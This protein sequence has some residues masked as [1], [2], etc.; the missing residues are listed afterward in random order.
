MEYKYNKKLDM[1]SWECFLFSQQEKQLYWEEGVKNEKLIRKPN[2][3]RY[4]R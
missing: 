2:L 1:L 4:K 3:L